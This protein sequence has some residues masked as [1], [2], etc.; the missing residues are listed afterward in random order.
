MK[1]AKGKSWMHSDSVLFVCDL[2]ITTTMPCTQLVVNAYG[3]FH[4]RFAHR[5]VLS[6]PFLFLDH[7]SSIISQT[8]KRHFVMEAQ[9]EARSD[10]YGSRQRGRK[11]GPGRRQGA[12]NPRGSHTSASVLEM[13]S[14][15]SKADNA[16]ENV[17]DS[18]QQVME[19]QSKSSVSQP[20]L[21]IPLP[22][23]TPKF[24]ELS[25]DKLIH[26]ILLQTISEDMKYE[27]MTTVQ[28]A[29]IR[30]LLKDRAD[31]LAQAKT[32]TGK[33]IA[34][35]LPAIQ[36][37]IAR[38][39]KPGTK[40]SLL[41]ISPTREL[42]MQIAEEARALLQRL[43]QYKVC[44]AIG[45][46]NKDA[47]ERRILKG[48]DILIGTPG[49]LYDHLG[50]GNG[51]GRIA[52]MLQS[53]DTLVLDEADRLLDMGFLDSLKKII[54]CLPDRTVHNRQ[55]MLFSATVPEHVKK[56][57]HLALSNDYKFISTIV[58]GEVN[59]HER[60]P[61][62]L[63]VVPTFSDMAA[64]L[65]GALRQELAHVG[66][67]TFKAIVFAPTAGLVD[68]YAEILQRSPGTPPVA[69]L[70]S[71]MTQ[72]RRSK[73]TEEFRQARSCVL[74]ATDVIA[75]GMDFPSVTNVF[76]AGVPSDKESYVH[77]LGRTARAGADG[78]GT[79]VLTTHESFFPKYQLRDI[80]FEESPADLSAG[81]DVLRIA[82]TLEEI[83]TR[84]YQAWLGYYK[85]HIKAM[86]WDNARLVQ[87]ANK[88][89][90]VG[91]GAPEVP[92]LRKSTVS[93]MGLKGVKG[94]VVGP[95]APKHGQGGGGGRDGGWGGSASK[96]PRN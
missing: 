32:G 4:L 20:S 31:V 77:R 1:G 25:D 70:H 7:N 79:L 63:V 9:R 65:L 56:V 34:F 60:V 59:T 54:G 2:H 49:R 75:R 35:L 14:S 94:L 91:L 88:F 90:L 55:G 44:I 78:R 13:A 71:R 61:Q 28:A 89:A 83:L 69:A 16:T 29:T 21:T 42:A 22:A 53:L 37:L 62:R 51:S 27:H 50:G 96:R 15:L 81:D 11:R 39:M 52:E 67:A 41:V 86:G 85:T 8:P 64:G 6:T 74:V 57:A 17:D 66:S 12:P 73:I 80:A 72:N 23:D 40:V 30:P 93:K 38:K 92:T 46:T 45:G 5:Y 19:R 68:F 36:N 26:P 18:S 87:E 24:S 95:D 10:A 58:E 33:T 76:Q 48:C 3:R 43:P 82:A 47:E 84:T